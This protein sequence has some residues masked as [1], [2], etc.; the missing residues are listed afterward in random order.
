M[1]TRE[2]RVHLSD[3]FLLLYLSYW[4]FGICHFVILSLSL[5]GLFYS[6]F[7]LVTGFRALNI[8]ALQVPC[9]ITIFFHLCIGEA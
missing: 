1:Y 7:K 8:E 6:R 5:S 3:V 4:L 9:Q 2:N